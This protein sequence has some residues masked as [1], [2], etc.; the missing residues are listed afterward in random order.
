MLNEPLPKQADLRKLA[1]RHASFT[2]NSDLAAFPRVVGAVV[3]NIGQVEA[4]LDFFV[5]EQHIACVDGWVK[6]QAQ[7]Q[8]QRCLEPVMVEF[9]S[10][11]AL[12]MI[13]DDIQARNLPKDR[14]PL[15]VEDEES[16]DLNEMLEDELLLAMPFVSY[17]EP[18]HCKGQQFY[19]TA[20]PVEV[21]VEKKENPFSV[22]AQL[23]PNK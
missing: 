1:A 11:I 8:C 12:A 18:E 14:D 20:Q 6:C 23:K 10:D 9:G 3:D 2:V 13:K 15:M 22:L 4:Q 17:H 5:D 16:F 21:P 19:Q 7:M